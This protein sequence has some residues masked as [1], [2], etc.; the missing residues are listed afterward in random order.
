[1]EE[2]VSTYVAV[3]E[4]MFSLYN[5]IQTVNAEIDNVVE[6]QNQI[7]I[8]IEVYKQQQLEQELVYHQLTVE[9]LVQKIHLKKKRMLQME[10]F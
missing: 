9:T 2:I 4:E 8:D 5:F 3:E 6:Q 7:V 1:M 10:Q